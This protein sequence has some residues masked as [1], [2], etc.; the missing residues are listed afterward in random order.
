MK[1]TITLLALTCIA[2]WATPPAVNFE[3]VPGALF[4]VFTVSGMPIKIVT[5]NMLSCNAPKEY[6]YESL[7]DL[8]TDGSGT[9]IS[10]W[11]GGVYLCKGENGAI[12]VDFNISTTG[13]TYIPDTMSS[14]I[15]GKET[16]TRSFSYSGE[17]HMDGSAV[18]ADGVYIAL[19][20]SGN[21]TNYML[22]NDAALP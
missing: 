18:A 22:L 7:S 10:K 9:Q 13:T 12:A 8:Q 19:T 20:P 15:I 3:V 14:N 2:G 1:N 16:H 6:T 21:Y 4:G 17:M 11:N 5:A